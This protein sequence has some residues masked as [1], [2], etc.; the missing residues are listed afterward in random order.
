MKNRELFKEIPVHPYSVDLWVLFADDVHKAVTRLC[1]KNKG[2]EIK[3]EDDMAAWTEDVFY[4]DY[5]LPVIFDPSHFDPATGSHEAVHIKNM[6][7]QHAGI[8]HDFKNDEPEAYLLGWIV[9][10]LQKAYDEF[11]KL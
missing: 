9:G 3:W 11:R 7:Y 4:R 6:I 1:L 5:I 10:E 8:K 2:L